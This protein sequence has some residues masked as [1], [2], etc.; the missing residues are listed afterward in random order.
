MTVHRPAEWRTSE[1]MRRQVGCATDS[2]V[3]PGLSR[4]PRLYDFG[5]QGVDARHEAGHDS[6]NFAMHD[7]RWI[8]D[9]PEAF[10]RALKRRG[11]PSRRRRG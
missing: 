7:I 8:R 5:Q 6:G 10:D 1:D 9:N 11:L 2:A 4:H 3:M